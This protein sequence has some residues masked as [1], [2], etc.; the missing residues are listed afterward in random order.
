MRSSRVA[1][2]VAVSALA[3]ALT[4][5]PCEAK[6][7]K[8]KRSKQNREK[9]T[10]REEEFRT[11]PP[12]EARKRAEEAISLATETEPVTAQT[13]HTHS[14][15][16]IN[17]DVDAR[18]NVKSQASS[19]HA[20]HSNNDQVENLGVIFISLWQF[21]LAELTVESWQNLDERLFHAA[22]DGNVKEVEALMAAGADPNGYLND[23][24][25]SALMNAVCMHMILRQLHA[26]NLPSSRFG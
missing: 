21:L 11:A 24:K 3:L 6:K 9:L 20:L 23:N 19:P 5:L 22:H 7:G 8:I 13:N 25:F 12:V 1:L 10:S 2:L 26:M 4:L 14:D 15:R 16:E 18:E 17:P